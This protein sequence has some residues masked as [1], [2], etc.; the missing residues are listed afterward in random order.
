ML[1]KRLSKR[2]QGFTIIEVMIVLAIAAVI[3][4][5]I[6]LA[7]P[8]LTRSSHNTQRKN[9]AAHLAGVISEWESNNG[10][11]P[12]TAFDGT[13]GPSLANENFSI[14]AKPTTVTTTGYTAPAS[15]ALDTLYVFSKT[16]CNGN[17]PTA[18]GGAR[19][20]ALVF[21]VEPGTTIQCVSAS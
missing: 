1:I 10:G 6:F 8:A 4:L 19:S 14:M 2:Q 16:T 13:G 15:P 21:Y 17:T 11:T 12:L 20:V 9:D 5:A 18:G 7:V 3:L